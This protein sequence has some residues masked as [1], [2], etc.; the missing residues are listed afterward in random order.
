[1]MS[2]EEKEAMGWSMFITR[3]PKFANI[4]DQAVE[5]LNAKKVYESLKNFE[6]ND[7]IKEMTFSR[8]LVENFLYNVSNGN[9]LIPHDK[10][11][12]F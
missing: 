6:D 4:V 1:M 3:P 9:R 10:I 5:D 11:K 2:K 8:Q 12:F 7:K